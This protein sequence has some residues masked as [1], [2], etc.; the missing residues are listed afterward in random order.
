MQKTEQAELTG[1]PGAIAGWPGN[2][3]GAA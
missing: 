1:I 3:R 2:Y